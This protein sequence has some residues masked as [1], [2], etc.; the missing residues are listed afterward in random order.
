MERVRDVRGRS[1]QT[2]GQKISLSKSATS[3]AASRTARIAHS[4][5]QVLTILLN[6]RRDWV[7]AVKTMATLRLELEEVVW[8]ESSCPRGYKPCPLPY[9]DGLSCETR[10]IVSNTSRDKIN[11]QRVSMIE[12]L[13]GLD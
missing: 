3:L 12:H 10:G 4:R 8:P 5:Y 6:M 11:G 13:S 2:S 1:A 9:L 7:L